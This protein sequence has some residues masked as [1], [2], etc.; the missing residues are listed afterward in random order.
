MLTTTWSAGMA[1]TVELVQSVPLETSLAEPGLR[2]TS[3]VWL[4][5]VQGANASLD[6]EQFYLSATPEDGIEDPVMLKVDDAIGAA[7]KRGVRVRLLLDAGFFK[8]YPDDAK[9][10]A[11]NANVTLKTIDVKA[12]TGGIQHSKF[13][14][15]DGKWAFLGSPNFDWRALDHVHEIG[16]RTDD[17]GVSSGLEAV[18]AKDWA[19]GVLVAGK[20]GPAPAVKLVKGSAGVDFYASPKLMNPPGVNDTLTALLVKI[21]GAQKSV[22]LQTYEYSTTLYD[23]AQTWTV[24]QDALT[25]AAGR[26]VKVR[27]MLDASKVKTGGAALRTLAGTPNVEVKSVRIPAWSGG[28]ISYAR[29][30]HSKYMVFDGT[31]AWVGTENL[32]GSYFETTRNVGV[33][34][35]DPKLVGELEGVFDRVWGST[36]AKAVK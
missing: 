8:T 28:P 22:D 27:L 21:Q 31:S 11:Q 3:E 23:S 15:A 18:F 13:F 20:D 5:M 29:L 2:S 14:V 4:E 9:A 6:I 26:G 7:A 16:I 34:F 32:E 33:M 36:Y 17:A 19:Q 35:N 1:A 10:L 25:A 30:I 24:L 12:L